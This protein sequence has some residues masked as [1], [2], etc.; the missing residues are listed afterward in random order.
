MPSIGTKVLS[1][2]IKEES[3]VYFEEI[4]TRHGTTLPK[5]FNALAL[6]DADETEA[7]LEV[8]MAY[9]DHLYGERNEQD[10]R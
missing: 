5:V 10:N 9:I 2:R 7:A 8:A 6:K 1:I 3:K 4:A